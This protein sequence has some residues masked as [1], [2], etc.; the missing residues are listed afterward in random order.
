CAHRLWVGR[1]RNPDEPAGLSDCSPV[2]LDAPAQ[3]PRRSGCGHV[4]SPR[5]PRVS[6]ARPRSSRP[7][8]R[9]AGLSRDR[10]SAGR[11]ARHLLRPVGGCHDHRKVCLMNLLLLCLVGLMCGLHAATWG[12]FKDSPFEGFKPGSF[13]RSVLLGLG[14]ALGLA[15]ATDL[16]STQPLLLLVGLCYAL[17]RLATAQ[18]EMERR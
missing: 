11:P 17:E 5:L 9:L 2:G 7:P 3:R 13:V 16:A 14:A 15:L 18:A 12:G 1:P 6:R 8:M 10:P 4:R